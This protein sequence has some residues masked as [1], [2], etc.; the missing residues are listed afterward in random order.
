[1][2]TAG[3]EIWPA[4]DADPASMTPRQA[5]A[6]TPWLAAVPDATLDLLARQ[7]VLHRM[8][9][10]STLFEQAQTPTFALLLVSGSVELLAMRG[11]DETLIEIVH[12]PDLLLP[13]AV[14]NH[15]P[16]LLKARVL[17]ASR[18]VMVQAE[19]FREAIASDH[20]FCLAGLACQ[21]AQFRRQIKH[22]KNRQLRS[23]EERV[24]CYL[25]RLAEAAPSGEPVRLPLGKRLIASQLGITRET[26]SRAL[27]TVLRHGIRVEGDIV[28][29]DDADAAR[30]RFRLDPLIDGP[31]PL[32]PLPIR[33]TRP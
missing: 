27:A 21:A 5:L 11:N 3:T 1:M 6:D 22:A 15:L 10:G 9:P 13:A 12:A 32:H 33:E 23:A 24:G 28:H 29:L 31:E 26:F 7:A 8:P 14:L 16:Y 20:A 18:L 4:S 2:L 17:E 25:L 19:T 30:A